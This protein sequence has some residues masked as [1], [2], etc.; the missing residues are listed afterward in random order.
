MLCFFLPQLRIKTKQKP[1][2]R[3]I[4]H[5]CVSSACM[6]PLKV[7]CHISKYIQLSNKN[8]KPDIFKAQL[9]ISHQHKHA[10]LG[11]S[12]TSVSGSYIFRVAQAQNL[13]GYP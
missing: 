7:Q 10:V 1:I 5:I 12:P 13:F 2:D 6:S 3:L 4:N 11:T 9:P 8:L